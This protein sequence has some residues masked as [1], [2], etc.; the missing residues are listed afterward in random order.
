MFP[1]CDIKGGVA[2]M[3]RN[4]NE[5]FEPIGQLI[6]NGDLHQIAFKIQE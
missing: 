1:E 5:L 6:P 4:K 3:Y 2:I